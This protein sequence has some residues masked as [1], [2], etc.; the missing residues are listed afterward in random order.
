MN[1]LE[2]QKRIRE[3]GNVLFLILIA[4]ALFAA[5]SY[6]VTQSS[7][8]G[9]G[10]TS[11]ETALI[12]SA[13]ITQYPA[14]IRTTIIR[15]LVNGTD[16]TELHFNTPADF[17]TLGENR[18]GVFHP[19][20]G[21]AIY[22]AA[23]PDIMSDYA[24]SKGTW[25]FNANIALPEIGTPATEADSNELVAYLPGITMT[26]CR[27]LNEELGITS[28]SANNIPEL[29][30]DLQ[31]TYKVHDLVDKGTGTTFPSTV[32][33]IT[34]LETATAGELDGQPYG[35]FKNPSATPEYVYYHVLVE[36]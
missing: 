3:S 27:K 29:S 10:D 16:V 11:G 21:G 30:A 32:A 12:N 1:R 31:G 25:Y 22:S 28:A 17:S 26:V 6:A 7:R 13:Q 33:D 4:V 9:G 8:S 2:H 20:G 19:S 24:D 15:M 34:A 35:C 23:P 18:V 5:L 36:R 14:S